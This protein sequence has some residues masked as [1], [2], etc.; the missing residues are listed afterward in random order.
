MQVRFIGRD[1]DIEQLKKL[2]GAPFIGMD[3]EWRPPMSS[4]VKARPG[5]MQL[6]DQTTAYLIDLVALAESSALDKVL[7]DVFTHKDSV[8]I[9]F[10]F[11]SDMSMLSKGLPK[12]TFSNEFTNFIDL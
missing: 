3:C 5:L 12:M 6:S 2:I 11:S 7:T 9:G 10:G 1:Q 8:L 4:F